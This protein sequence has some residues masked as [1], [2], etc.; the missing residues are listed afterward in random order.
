MLK[1]SPQLPAS[2]TETPVINPR[3]LEVTS[4][5]LQNQAEDPDVGSPVEQTFEAD[6]IT[7]QEAEAEA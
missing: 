4:A 5:E 1:I 7:L 3:S 2:A 6:S